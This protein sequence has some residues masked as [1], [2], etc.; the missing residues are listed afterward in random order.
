MIDDNAASRSAAAHLLENAGA[1]VTLADGAAFALAA[2]ELLEGDVDFAAVFIDASLPD[3]ERHRPGRADCR[4][5]ARS[6]VFARDDAWLPRGGSCARRTGIRRVDFEAGRTQR[7]SG[8]VARIGGRRSWRG[9]CRGCVDGC[10]RRP[11]ASRRQT[12]PRP[13]QPC[14]RNSPA[15]A[16]RFSWL[17]TASTIRNSRSVCWQN[18]VIA[19]SWRTMGARRWNWSAR[20]DST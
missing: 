13:A 12:R 4:P 10:S 16:C 11:L 18:A 19:S 9:G 6:P 14:V 17:K 7:D 15:A 3:V 5:L 20:T 2:I 8:R 1:V